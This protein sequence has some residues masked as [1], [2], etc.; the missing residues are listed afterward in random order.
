[1]VE[2]LLDLILSLYIKEYNDAPSLNFEDEKHN[3]FK[4]LRELFSVSID[5]NF[6]YEEFQTYLI[7]KYDI[8]L[9][10]TKKDSL[11]NILKFTNSLTNL[12]IGIYIFENNN[13][14]KINCNNTNYVAF[15]FKIN[16]DDYRLVVRRE[17]TVHHINV[18]FGHASVV[19]QKVQIV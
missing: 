4:K 11:K 1:M 8:N 5:Q 17:V 18:E 15:V 16:S 13:I 9:T 12:N 6:N 7:N 14:K 10:L 3:V 2:N 19:F